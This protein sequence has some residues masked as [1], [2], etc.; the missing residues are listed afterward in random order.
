MGDKS[1]GWTVDKM[2]VYWA[3]WLVVP[4]ADLKV[5]CWGQRLVETKALQMAAHLV[6]VKAATLAALKV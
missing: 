5:A 6:A 4:M 2:V 3:V 1:V